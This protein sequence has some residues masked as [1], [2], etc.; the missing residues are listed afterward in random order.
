MSKYHGENAVLKKGKHT[1][2]NIF[3]KKIGFCITT[4]QFLEIF[5]V[6]LKWEKYLRGNNIFTPQL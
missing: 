3:V 2:F 5:F 1:I 4:F 6:D